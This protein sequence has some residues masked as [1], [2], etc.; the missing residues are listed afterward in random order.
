MVEPCSWSISYWTAV[1]NHPPHVSDSFRG[2][3]FYVSRLC[4]YIF[5][6]PDSTLIVLS[7]KPRLTPQICLIPSHRLLILTTSC[8][9]PGMGRLM[10]SFS[11]LIQL[12]S[13]ADFRPFSQRPSH[14]LASCRSPDL[15]P[16]S[17]ILL[18]LGRSTH[19]F[20]PN[21]WHTVP[22]QK[23]QEKSEQ[24]LGGIITELPY[25]PW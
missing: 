2:V 15:Y 9:G 6:D 8:P 21:S 16:Y 23:Y 18:R 20:V 11:Q 3:I 17:A 19:M 14:N 1:S 12:L 10:A 24:P 7:Y 5:H 13:S 22:Y 4:S 25:M